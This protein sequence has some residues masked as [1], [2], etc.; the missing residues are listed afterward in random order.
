MRQKRPTDRVWSPRPWNGSGKTLVR[1][2]SSGSHASAPPRACRTRL[3]ASTVRG[4]HEPIQARNARVRQDRADN[5]TA[6]R[7]V[8]GTRR[9]PERVRS[10]TVRTQVGRLASAALLRRVWNGQVRCRGDAGLHHREAR[11]MFSLACQEARGWMAST[12]R[13]IGIGGRP[14]AIYRESCEVGHGDSLVHTAQRPSRCCR[15]MR[16]GQRQRLLP[17]AETQWGRTSRWS[18]LAAQS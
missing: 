11:R 16:F 2:A 1:G 3:G 15:V 12:S 8:T 9:V 7:L 13:W 17:V 10:A 6:G 4:Q 5:R 18:L 14:S